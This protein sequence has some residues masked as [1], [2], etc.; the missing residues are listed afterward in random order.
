MIKLRHLSS[1]TIV[2]AVL[3]SGCTER[4]I[5]H[6]PT[7]VQANSPDVENDTSEVETDKLRAEKLVATAEPLLTP[8]GFF[9]A[10]EVLDAAL[11]VD[12]KNRKA[13]FYKAML[14]PLMKLR[15][16]ISRTS[17][18]AQFAAHRLN[19][20]VSLFER[21]HGGLRD[22]LRESAPPIKTER[23]LQE[24]INEILQEQTKSIDFIKKNMS[25]ITEISVP[26]IYHFEGIISGCEVT[27]VG[28]L[29]YQLSPCPYQSQTLVRM[30]RGDWEALLQF[31]NGTRIGLILLTSYNMEGYFDYLLKGGEFRMNKAT[32]FDF[33]ERNSANF[34]RLHENHKLKEV[35]GLASDIY[36]GVSW[37]I[38]HQ[39]T[40]CSTEIRGKHL[41]DAERLCFAK[42]SRTFNGRQFRVE[43]VVDVLKN[44]V[45]GQIGTLELRTNQPDKTTKVTMVRLDLLAAIRNPIPNLRLILPKSYSDKCG[46]VNEYRDPTFGGTFPDR[47]PKLFIRES[48][49]VCYGN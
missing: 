26:N 45:T 47:N 30:N 42:T 18:G 12:P 44:N 40:F 11:K 32:A 6:V 46:T 21:A 49:G 10:D 19:F 34:G 17:R 13:Q 43:N 5:E 7:P 36:S 25:L 4:I 15:G 16:F 22:F 2:I 39:D 28:P 41:F 8:V 3:M 9:F 1:L 31:A 38:S 24:F 29:T 27:K 33:L 20:D 23:E 14:A 48:L 37:L 35:M